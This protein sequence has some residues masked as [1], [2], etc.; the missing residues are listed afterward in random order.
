[1]ATL[2]E[3]QRQLELAQLE[4][5][6]LNAQ[7]TVLGQQ[8]A[9][10]GYPTGG[11]LYDQVVANSLARKEVASQIDTLIIQI[12]QINSSGT[13]AG[14]I[15]QNDDQATADNASSQRPQSPPLTLGSDGRIKPQPDTTSGTNAQVS[16]TPDAQDFGTDDELRPT[17]ITQGTPG[18]SQPNVANGSANNAVLTQPVTPQPGGEPGAAAGS[19]DAGS[20][21]VTV[22]EIDTIFNEQLIVPSSNVL[23]QY[24][25]YN[26]TASVYLMS[27]AAIGEMMRSKRKNLDGAQLLFQTGGA[28]VSGRNQFFSNDY[29]IDSIQLT[30]SVAGKGT[31]APHN[32]NEVR[33]TVV[34]P[35]GITLLENLDLAVQS[36]LGKDRKKVSYAA[37]NYLLVIR[38]YGYDVN[39]NLVRGGVPKVDGS[40]DESAFVEKFYP[41][42]IQNIRFRVASKGVEYNIEAT[43][44]HYST[45]VGTNRGTIPYN[46]ELG[47]QTVKDILT[48]PSM[49]NEQTLENEGGG[50]LILDAPKNINAA[51]SV[52]PNIRQGLFTV[53]NNIQANLVQQG[54]YDVADVYEIEFVG[55]AIPNAPLTKLGGAQGLAT[56]NTSMAIPR[57]PNQRLLGNLSMNPATRVDGIVAGT[58]II[59]V[60]DTIVRNSKYIQDQQL[61]YWDEKAKSWKSNPTRAKNVAWYKVSLEAT[62]LAWDDKRKDFAYRMKYVVHPYRVDNAPPPYFAQPQFKGTHKLYEYWFTG[63]NTQVLSYEESYN[64]QYSLV[65]TG[66]L[67]AALAKQT[68]NANQLQKFTSATNSSESSQQGDGFANEASANFADFLYNPGDLA[69]ADMTIVGDPA[70]LQQGEAFAGQLTSAW[71]FNAFMPDGTINFDAQTILFEILFN[72]PV[73]YDLTTGLID[74]GK[75]NF[76]S[77]RLAG[78]SGRA[79]QSRIYRALQV[80]STFERGKFTQR[81]VGSLQQFATPTSTSAYDLTSLQQ[82][83]MDLNEAYSVGRI[84]SNAAAPVV[85]GNAV[86]AAVYDPYISGISG[87]IVQ[88]TAIAG[89]RPTAVPQPPTSSGLP[90]GTVN[91]P[92]TDTTVGTDATVTGTEQTAA[93]DDDSGSGTSASNFPVNAESYE[94]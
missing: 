94:T 33:M 53:I 47:G 35:N 9:A 81:L 91:T 14:N 84:G 79:R 46:L 16:P 85:P 72:R 5:Q 60:I 7:A 20:N 61:Y 63:Q 62:P 70:W 21:N 34:E 57:D 43:A 11:A 6:R 12:S 90:V 15:V 24:S 76:G 38:F 28:P 22:Q 82:Q 17:I 68:A 48:G 86:N 55:S 73:D 80:Y 40:T 54:R 58:Q 87:N 31:S 25:T 37:A 32:V 89:T 83:A 66:G 42:M 1:M 10:A 77:N 36:F 75:N 88:G 45:S 93:P 3:L 30:S 23:D 2:V 59:K 92:P 52:S 74:P 51:P 64:Y 19:D 56:D 67:P 44:P 29:Y 39:G 49:F 78:Q 65:L 69:T 26:Y 18:Q 4:F 50:A 27:L 13:S 71:N 8:Y 41:L